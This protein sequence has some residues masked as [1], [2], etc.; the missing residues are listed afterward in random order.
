M[1]D[2]GL[3]LQTLR[4]KHNMSQRELGERLERSKSVICAYENNL[5]MPTVEVL[6]NIAALFNVSV[7]Y[8]VGIDKNEMI[9]VD[10]LNDWQKDIVYGIVSELKGPDIKYPGLSDNQQQLLNKLLVEFNKKHK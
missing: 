5:R 3:R 2:F 4:T 1:F 7:D 6:T 10:G 8:L 9:S